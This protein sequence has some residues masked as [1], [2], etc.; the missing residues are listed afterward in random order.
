MRQ[1]TSPIWAIS[2]EELIEIVNKE[3]TLTGILKHFG[4]VNKGR[5]SHTL[6]KRLEED[7]IDYSHIPLGINTNKGRK[8]PDTYQ[9]PLDQALVKN[10]SY[11]RSSLKK[12]IIKNN[13]I[14]YKCNECGLLPEWQGKPI[15]IQLDHI[16]GLYNDNRLKNL[17]FLCPNCHSQTKNF[18]GKALR[19]PKKQHVCLEC[20]EP[21]TGTGKT[22]KC[23]ICAM[24]DR[25][26]LSDISVNKLSDLTNISKSTV[27]QA[28]SGKSVSKKTVKSINGTLK[29][30]N[31]PLLDER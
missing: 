20:A 1:R 16:N 3:T 27:Y 28:L 21:I 26:I 4:L 23:S 10:S 25:R 9:I 12:R 18:A 6:K 15:T 19:K 24:K 7:S 5:N 11:S 2:K 30:N 29:Q 8:F 22:G 14:E 31:L 17:R 13:I